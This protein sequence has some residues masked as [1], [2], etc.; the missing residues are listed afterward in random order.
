MKRLGNAS[1]GSILL[2]SIFVSIFL[3]FLSVALIWT[4][5]QDI[6]LSLSMDNKLKAQVAARTGAMRT[7]ASLRALARPPAE[8]R[9]TLSSGA[10][11]E[12]ELVRLPAEEKRGPAI[13][14]KARGTSGAV[15]SY[16]T[17]HLLEVAPGGPLPEGQGRLL[18][19]PTASPW[20]ARSPEGVPELTAFADQGSASPAGPAPLLFGDFVQGEATLQVGRSYAAAQGPLFSAFAEKS[21]GSVP[22]LGYLPVAQDGQAPAQAVGP[23]GLELPAPADQTRIAVLRYGQELAWEDIP[24]PAVEPPAG[25]LGA[26]EM[27]APREGSWTA[28]TPTLEHR[29][30]QLRWSH[31][32]QSASGI[33]PENLVPMANAQSFRSPPSYSLRGA[34]AASG[35]VLYCHAWQYTFAAQEGG[36]SVT[37]RPCILSYS[38]EGQAWTT[39]W[40]Y[41][42]EGPL[43]DPAVLAASSAGE[44]FSLS[45]DQ[46]PRLLQLEPGGGITLGPPVPSGRLLVYRDE[47]YTVSDDARSAGFSQLRT[48]QLIDFSSLTHEVPEI[49]GPLLQEPVTEGD[50]LAALRER[51]LIAGKRLRYRVDRN[52]GFATEG[53]SLYAHLE[54]EVTSL[55]PAHPSWGTFEPESTTFRVLGRYDGKNWHV[56][57]AGLHTALRF[58]KYRDLMPLGN[59][60]FCAHY[61]DLPP[62]MPRY[63][64]I[65]ISLAPFEVG[66]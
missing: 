3:F 56:L 44:L 39:V 17:L 53:D 40:T 23:V 61:P 20:P 42:G 57:P 1:R 54:V 52:T 51:T 63:A 14:V 62:A 64:V 35:S 2:T 8:L 50:P 49:A 48:S 66:P 16:F 60:I 47:P 18:G 43:P 6:A 19:F 41:A 32:G 37:R 27:A 45:T 29:D 58:R 33:G 59:G 15:S 34:V 4:N 9:G 22:V 7:Y 10:A 21:P 26:V 12:V 13:L 36:A 5:R 65:G 11:W 28:P 38:L 55:E 24:A 30:G 46:V 25:V 31:T